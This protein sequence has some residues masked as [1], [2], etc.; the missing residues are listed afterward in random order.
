[1]HLPGGLWAKSGFRKAFANF[2]WLAVERFVR[3]ATGVAVGLVVARYLGPAQFGMLSFCLA[4]IGLLSV[5]PGLGL[6]ALVKREIIRRPAESSVLLACAF[7]L[8]LIAGIVGVAVLAGAAVGSTSLLTA[9]EGRLLVLL[10][11]LLLQPALFA[12]DLWLQATLRARQA[13]S[14]QLAALVAASITRLALVLMDAP[15]LAFGAVLVAEMALVALGLWWALKRAGLSQAVWAGYDAGRAKALLREAWPLMLTGFAIL[16]YMKIDQVML[17]Q[18][19]G[20]RS[21]GVYAAAVRLSELWYF[22]PVAMASSLLPALLRAR[23]QGA[24]IYRE[25]LQQFFDLNAGVA[26]VLAVPLALGSGWVV[27]VA[28]GLD[29][30]EAGPVLAV[31]IWASLFVFIGVARSQW[32]V[33][34][35]L[36][37]FYL[38]CTVAGA[39]VNIGLNVVLIPR[40][41]AQGAAWATLAAYGVAA[42]LASFAHR[43]VRG[44]GFMQTRALLLP[45][46]GWRYLRRA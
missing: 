3:L 13:A 42:W 30:A 11:L 31:H 23:E 18:M 45:I 26:Y 36:S 10:S 24:E 21:V 25:R 27:R 14:A 35:G 29:Y 33:N 12:P 7:R 20:A 39:I 17:R 46:L 37:R 41:G 32:L 8:R 1:M 22:V 2:G 6:E 43:S 28:Y 4:V 15:L 19:G 40:W 34:E 5:G 44:V 16:I 38:V 9:E